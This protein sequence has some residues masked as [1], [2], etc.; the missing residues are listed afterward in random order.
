MS[1][2]S[3]AGAAAREADLLVVRCRLPPD[4]FDFA[5]RLRGMV[6][7]IVGLDMIPVD[8]AT[9]R[10]LPMAKLRGCTAM[11][12]PSMC[13]PAWASCCAASAA[14]TVGFARPAGTTAARWPG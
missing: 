11:R 10:G 12:W 3:E 6:R 14:W 9:A 5:L 4:I 8:A 1:R 13:W 7:Q 2:P